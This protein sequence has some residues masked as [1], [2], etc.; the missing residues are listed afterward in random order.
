MLTAPGQ[1]RLPEAPYSLELDGGVFLRHLTLGDAPIVF[2]TVDENR[3]SLRQWLPWVDT[4]D[5][6]AETIRFIQ[7][8]DDERKQGTVLVYGIWCELEFC[9]TISLHAIDASNLRAQIGYWL[10]PAA[11]RRGLVTHA[12]AALLGIAF[13]ILDLERVEICCGTANFRSCAIPQRLGF[14]LEGIARKAQ[15]LSGGFHDLCVYSLL[16]EEY[17]SKLRLAE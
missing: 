9:G 2:H 3:V 15:R 5:S 16:A 14:T 4:N 13:E 11:Q 17:R 6:V 12:C 8:S 7:R 1:G 10:K